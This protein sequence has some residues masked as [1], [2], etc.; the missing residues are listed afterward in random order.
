MLF[1]LSHKNT[2]LK[3]LHFHGKAKQFK[4]RLPFALSK[5]SKQ[6]IFQKVERLVRVVT[7]IKTIQNV[8]KDLLG[9][10]GKGVGIFK[11]LLF[12]SCRCKLDLD[13][14]EPNVQ[15]LLIVGT[16]CKLSS[17]CCRDR[18]GQIITRHVGKF[19]KSWQSPKV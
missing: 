2:R 18:G 10:A 4:V 19:G 12:D 11:F 3:A 1:K 14:A 16:K 15:F 6:S 9:Q 5:L 17:C 13:E 7:D 8:L